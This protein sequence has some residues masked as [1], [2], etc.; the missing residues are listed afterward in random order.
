M[1]QNADAIAPIRDEGQ[2]A[3]VIHVNTDEIPECVV[4][5]LCAATRK[6]VLKAMR[7]KAERESEKAER[8]RRAG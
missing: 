5:R 2:L 6:M 7:A 3:D 8:K 1:I 4:D